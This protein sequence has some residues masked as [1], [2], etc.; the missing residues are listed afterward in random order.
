MTGI[1]QRR[2]GGHS[3]ILATYKRVSLYFYW[4]NEG[5]HQK[6]AFKSVMFAEEINQNVYPPQDSCNHFLYQSMY[7]KTLAWTSM[8]PF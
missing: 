2:C 7:G 6:D 8:R 3:R 5:I 4:L 1:A